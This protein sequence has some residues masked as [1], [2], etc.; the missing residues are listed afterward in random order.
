MLKSSLSSENMLSD[1][2]LSK[3]TDI[4]VRIN[5]DTRANKQELEHPSVEQSASLPQLKLF[6]DK[7]KKKAMYAECKHDFVDLLFSLLV[8]P[9]NSTIR[10][11]GGESCLS[12]NFRTLYNSAIDL[13]A[14]GFLTGSPPCFAPFR[15]GFPS[16]DMDAGVNFDPEFL[17]DLFS[18]KHEFAMD[19]MYVVEDD[20]R[21]YE[22]SRGK[23]V[24][25]F[26]QINCFDFW[27][28]VLCFD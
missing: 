13:D 14:A 23:S 22:Q 1:T 20:L 7:H 5:P 27:L 28:I 4:A 9:V 8:F 25:R 11:M 16:G 18:D 17:S 15:M 10:Y 6:V 12:R 2:F 21:Y 19:R 3:G 26:L 24:P